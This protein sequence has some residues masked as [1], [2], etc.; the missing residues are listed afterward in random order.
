LSF[1]FVST[2]KTNRFA[3][4]SH[5]EGSKSS[6]PSLFLPLF[7]FPFPPFFCSSEGLLFLLR[8]AGCQFLRV[9]LPTPFVVKPRD[10]HFFPISPSLS[11]CFRLTW[12]S[13]DLLCSPGKIPVQVKNRQRFGR[14]SKSRSPPNSFR[15]V[16][17]FTGVARGFVPFCVIFPFF[18]PPPLTYLSFDPPP[19][20]M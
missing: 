11:L 18:L 15:L 6:P 14:C 10:L 2:K 4:P 16:F 20:R 12:F 1:H 17:C 8:R 9:S 13:P 3:P 7:F 5:R 19:G